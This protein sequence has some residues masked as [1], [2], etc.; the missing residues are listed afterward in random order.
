[1]KITL[2]GKGTD[3]DPVRPDLPDY[4]SY[5]ITSQDKSNVEVAIPDS[6]KNKLMQDIDWLARY[7]K[8]KIV[9][10]EALLMEYPSIHNWFIFKGLPLVNI[11][12]KAILF[13]DSIQPQFQPLLDNLVSKKIIQVYEKEDDENL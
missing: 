9:A 12:D 11:K 1:M 2:T 13:C 7:Y 3:D 5:T 8:I 10:P 6:D 4:V